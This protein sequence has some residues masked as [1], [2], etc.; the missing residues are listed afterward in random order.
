MDSQI[1][2]AIFKFSIAGFGDGSAQNVLGAK[3]Q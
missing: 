1:M 2:K 3:E